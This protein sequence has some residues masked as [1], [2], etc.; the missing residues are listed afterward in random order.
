MKYRTLLGLFIIIATIY[1]LMHLFPSKQKRSFSADL[2]AVDTASVTSILLSPGG[3]S[4]EITLKKEPTGWIA[5]NGQ[6]NILASSDAVQNILNVMTSIKTQQVVATHRDQWTLYKIG[7]KQA[8]RVRVYE[9]NQMIEDFSI[10]QSTGNAYIR[11][12]NEEEVYAVD[13][14]LVI[15]FGQDFNAFRN[16]TLLK[17]ES[18][19]YVTEIEYQL[20]DTTFLLTKTS[21]GWMQDTMPL[22]V[23]KIE[24]YL[25]DLRN[26]SGETFADDFDEVQG[27][28]D[29]YQ[30]LTFKGKAITEPFVITCYRDTTRA[31]PFVLQS[32]QNKEAFFA[33][34]SNGIYKQIFSKVNGFVKRMPDKKM[35]DA[36]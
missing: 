18:G 33:S 35:P 8:T 32:N 11:L 25:A 3:N 9:G 31:L 20:V 7:P 29:L 2:I 15:D 12:A 13:G 22:N 5:S 14:A 23:E 27:S 21:N 28:K 1:G 4:G 17:M 16:R 26:I 24:N 19:M 6:I 10:S 36:R 30:I 34:D